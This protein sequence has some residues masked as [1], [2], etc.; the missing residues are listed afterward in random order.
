[1]SVVSDIQISDRIADLLHD[2]GSDPIFFRQKDRDVAVL[3]SAERY[4][5]LQHAVRDDFARLCDEASKEAQANGL[6][7]E[8]LAE[9]LAE[10]KAERRS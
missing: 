8:I 1:M 2:A 6:T 5:R 10:A 7:E 3:M 4:E 9:I